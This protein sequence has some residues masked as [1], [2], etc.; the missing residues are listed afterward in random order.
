MAIAILEYPIRTIDF[1]RSSGAWQ[2]DTGL[3]VLPGQILGR[4]EL[5]HL[6]YIA[7]KSQLTS[8]DSEDFADFLVEQDFPV[9]NGG[10]AFTRH[11]SLHRR[12]CPAK[13]VMIGII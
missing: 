6:A 9:N 12:Y 3:V 1:I 10:S 7:M 13:T 4:G 2:I 11:L 8:F 5:P